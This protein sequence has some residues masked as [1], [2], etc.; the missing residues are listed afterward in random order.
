[1]FEIFG[2]D[3]SP[4]AVATA[5]VGGVMALAVA[6]AFLPSRPGKPA[7]GVPAPSGQQQA[8]A[9]GKAMEAIKIGGCP[10]PI[11]METL[12]IVMS[13]APGT[14]KSFSVTGVLDTLTTRDAG[15][16]GFVADRSG[17]Y[18]SR[19]YSHGRGDIILNPLDRRAASWSPLSEFE[20]EWSGENLARSLVP[21]GD[22]SQEEWNAPARLFLSAILAHCHRHDMKNRDI[23]RLAIADP[24][25]SLQEV[26]AG[27]SA[28]GLI[29][30]GAEKFF[31]SV[32]A[33]VTTFISPL[34]RLDPSAGRDAFSIRRWVGEDRGAWVFWPYRTD[35]MIPMRS[36]IACMADVYCEAV[37]VL[38][39]SR[40][41]RRWLILDEFSSLG[42]VSSI[43]N[44]VTNSRKHGGCSILGLQSI[45]QLR[46]LY[47]E[48]NAKTILSS[49]ATSLILRTSDAD[50]A[51]YLSRQ[52]GDRQVTRWVESEGHSSN[53]GPGGGSSG[54]SSNRSQQ[55]VI[56]RTYL[57][58]QLMQMKVL[59]GILLLPGLGQRPVQV[60]VPPERD[61]VAA[62]WEPAPPRVQVT[63]AAPVVAPTEPGDHP[64]ADLAAQAQAQ[65]DP[66]AQ[67]DGIVAAEEAPA[68]QAEGPDPD[69]PEAIRHDLGALPLEE[70]AAVVEAARAV[71]QADQADK[72]EAS[73]A[74]QARAVRDP[75]GDG[76][77]GG[78][79]DLL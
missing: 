12:G 61:P 16:G 74:E 33:T 58:S 76:L 65:P 35:Q 66:L 2:T 67:L 8:K 42:R 41:R 25:E 36:L 37:M 32:R 54:S 17:I 6:R 26:L 23:L 55:I 9:S 22:P 28:A 7:R 5:A 18:L 53:S 57:P 21:M 64:P 30:P 31:A 15:D 68:P 47:G 13:G 50:T 75:F 38:P 77:G 79:A 20:D 60:P 63:T 69:S 70:R 73:L 11:S 29:Q 4:A 49:L 71:V 40:R 27:H 46:A 52:I 39:P 19:Y 44:W 45:A 51:E 14:G 72:E 78:G 34:N 1:M 56:E 62:A 43:E 24:A 3:Y 10:I 48:D 59:H